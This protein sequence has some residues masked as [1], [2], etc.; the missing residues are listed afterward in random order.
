MFMSKLKN[1]TIEN[2]YRREIFV[3]ADFHSSYNVIFI[4]GLT[5]EQHRLAGYC[6]SNRIQ[7]SVMLYYVLVGVISLHFH[8]MYSDTSTPVQC[9]TPFIAKM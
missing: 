2:D 9:R 8:S 1:Y 6:V 4:G 5:P 7:T 3:L